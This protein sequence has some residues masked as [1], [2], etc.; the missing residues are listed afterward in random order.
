[1]KSK[2]GERCTTKTANL[3]VLEVYGFILQNENADTDYWRT[4]SGPQN[5]NIIFEIYFT[6]FDWNELEINLKC[7]TTN[8]LEIFLYSI[9][10]GYTYNLIH[11]NLYKERSDLVEELTKNIS[12]KTDLILPILNIGI[13]RGRLKNDIIL[14]A[15]EEIY[16]LINHFDVLIDKDLNYLNKIKDILDVIG[17][18]YVLQENPELKNKIEEASR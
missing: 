8:Q 11:D 16:F 14:T 9:M 15:Q 1:M 5:L 2:Y 7:W 10:N 3:A 13:E 12:Y 18:D 6:E 17:Y 4:D